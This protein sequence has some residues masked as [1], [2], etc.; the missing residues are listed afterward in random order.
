[1]AAHLSTELMQ[2][3]KSFSSPTIPVSWQ[4]EEA[5]SAPAQALSRVYSLM[6]E[7]FHNFLNQYFWHNFE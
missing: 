3:R 2:D 7:C 1:M 6:N 4:E 5:F